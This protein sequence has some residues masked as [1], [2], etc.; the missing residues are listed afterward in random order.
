MTTP[1]HLNNVRK[2]VRSATTMDRSWK[3]AS[4]IEV[5]NANTA[6]KTAAL[7]A[8]LAALHTMSVKQLREIAN[9][10][11]VSGYSTMKKTALIEVIRRRCRNSL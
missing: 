1:N 2:R 3:K 9:R 7:K 6:K 11:G 10:C 5:I 4:A 8:K